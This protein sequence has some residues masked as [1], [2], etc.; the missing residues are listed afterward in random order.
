M[1]DG[2]ALHESRLQGSISEVMSNCKTKLT[3]V[4][5]F[6]CLRAFEQEKNN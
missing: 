1:S 6:T 3:V 4:T 5:S 2:D